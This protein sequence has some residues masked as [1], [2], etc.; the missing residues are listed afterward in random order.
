MPQRA[1]ELLARIGAEHRIE[2][3]VAV[4]QPAEIDPIGGK[5]C[6]VT[7]E[8]PLAERCS[9][10]APLRTADMELGGLPSK[11]GEPVD[12]LIPDNELPLRRGK[13]AVVLDRQRVEA[14][15]AGLVEVEPTCSNQPAPAAVISGSEHSHSD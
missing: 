7:S 14:R 5:G 9:G 4:L 8:P 15:I 10:Q 13:D 12:Q 3:P 1:P 11:T 2:S 6:F